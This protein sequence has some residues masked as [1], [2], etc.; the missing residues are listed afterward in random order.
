MSWFRD[1]IPIIG[2]SEDFKPKY[3]VD[4]RLYLEDRK[5]Q[6]HTFLNWEKRDNDYY[7]VYKEYCLN[8]ENNRKNGDGLIL[9]GDCGTGKTFAIDCIYNYLKDKHQVLKTTLSTILELSKSNFNSDEKGLNFPKFLENMLRLDLVIFDDLG[10]EKL[11]T[12]WSKQMAFDVF[13]TLYRNEIPFIITTNL[14]K[15]DLSKFFEIKGSLKILDRVQEV[16]RPLIYNKKNLKSFREERA[17]K[18]L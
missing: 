15:D 2:L 6:N 12:L 16:C 11:D 14:N 1:G 7:E 4:K 17:R 9:I 8:F 13:D 10:N 18:W 5:L 3:V